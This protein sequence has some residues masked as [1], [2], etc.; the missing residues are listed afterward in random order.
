MKHFAFLAASVLLALPTFAQKHILDAPQVPVH[1]R[2][3][4]PM[5]T[6]A[7]LDIDH[8]PE[9]PVDGTHNL[10]QD[11]VQSRDLVIERQVIGITQYDL[12]SN[13]A[14]DDR[15]AGNGSAV[16][17]AWTMSLDVTPF[18]DRG[19]GY[20]F[21]DG[22][23]WG[24]E[25]YERIEN[26]RIG[27]PSINHLGD[28]REVVISH[29]GIDTP[30]HMVRRDAGTGTWEDSDLP[31]YAILDDGNPV[32][33]LWPRA[34]VGGINDEIIHVICISTPVAN[35]GFEYQ[36]QDGAL[37]YYRSMDSGDTWE[38][39]TFPELD[40]SNFVNI[41]ADAYSIH[42]DGGMV[43]FAVFNDLSDS[44]IM[45]SDDAG[46]NWEYQVLADFP[47]D[48]YTIDTGLPDSLGIDFDGD[49]IAAEYLNSDGAGDVHI[50]ANGTV[51]CVY[52]G[53]YYADADT[54]DGNFSFFPGTN[55]LE[56]WRDDFGPDSSVTIA[57]AYDMDES[58]TLDLED[59]IAAYFVNLAGIPSMASD[60][61]GN[62][63]VS[64]SAV[65]EN[66]STG[67]QNYRHVYVVNSQDGGDNW[68]S[69]DA[70]DVTPDVA[71][72]GYESVFASMS[73]RLT[74][75]IELIYQRDF[76]P[77]LHVRGDEDPVDIN[78]IVHLRIPIAD[79]GDCTDLDFEDVVDVTEAFEPGDVQLFPNPASTQV[80]LVIDRPGSHFVRV[81]DL[82]GREHMAWNTTAMLER[83]GLQ[84]LSSGMYLVEVSQ[85]AHSTV[86]R[87]AVQ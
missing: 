15:M 77:G 1:K 23:G 34:A 44:F 36:G 54:V 17:A 39:T 52:G 66:F 41:S 16:S 20:N 8:R 10:V 5:P 45:I 35:G 72:D 38:M 80:E 19:T 33:N 4:A 69:E 13:A 79:L 37:L 81:V 58:G 86:V 30:L 22:S 7:V 75:D 74:D 46:D 55:G 67:L 26:V 51:H 60:D 50:D 21:Y 83:V 6:H 68:N 24:E 70:C 29:A 14:I 62:L 12:Q 25:P 76:E 2:V 78:D 18:E 87:L 3:K 53:M 63:Y 57:Y 42:A 31:N 85:G 82:N 84:G 61:N 43:A 47:V 9:T 48:L 27:W 59:E 64:Y 11:H 49:G 65:M 56:Y 40:S 32:G 28:G 73:P 71:F